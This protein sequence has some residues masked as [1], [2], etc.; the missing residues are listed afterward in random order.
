MLL[1]KL[2]R[3]CIIAAITLLPAAHEPHRPPMDELADQEVITDAVRAAIDAQ[4]YRTLSAMESDFRTTRAR[5]VSGISKLGLFHGRILAELGPRDDAQQCDDRSAD[6]FR[7]WVAA[8]P[9]SPAPY[10]SRAAVVEAL[11]WCIRGDGFAPSVS[12]QAFEGFSAKVAEAQKILTMHTSASIDPEYYA[13]KERIYIDQGADKA[14]FRKL[15]DEAVAREPDYPHLYFDA[16]RYFQPQWYGSD[17]EV[18]ELARYAAKHTSAAEGAGMYARFYWHAL[19]CHCAIDR[20]VDWPT[21]KEGMRDVW[22]RFPSDWNAANFARISCSMNDRAE[23][24]T[25]LARV[26]GDHSAA[27]DDRDEMERCEKMAQPVETSSSRCS[28]AALENW[29]DADFQRYCRQAT[30]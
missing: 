27:W 23:A 2:R 15:L 26:K 6:F 24:R 22:T 13:V 4:D 8:T 9:A 20:S 1:R 29:P 18:D 30:H 10:I 14:A 21:M 3:L 12:D 7:R 17:S 19:D 25:W 16:Y 11:A 28:F 5:T